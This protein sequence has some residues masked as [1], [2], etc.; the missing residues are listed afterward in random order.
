[1]QRVITDT[2]DIT[3]VDQAPRLNGRFVNAILV[4]KKT[5]K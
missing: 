1:M 4:P 3:T 5:Q 2:V